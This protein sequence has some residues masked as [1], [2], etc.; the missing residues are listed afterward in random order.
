[1][2][3]EST[4]SELSFDSQNVGGGGGGSKNKLICGPFLPYAGIATA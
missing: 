2:R 3:L 4:E 1:M